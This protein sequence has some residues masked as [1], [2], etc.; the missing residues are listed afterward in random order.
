M[1][2]RILF[3]L[4]IS[5]VVGCDKVYTEEE[6]ADL[7]DEARIDARSET[8]S[9]CSV[10]Q[11]FRILEEIEG[12]SEE[13]IRALRLVDNDKPLGFASSAIL[14]QRLEEVQTLASDARG[15]IGYCR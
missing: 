6:V 1:P 7:L 9:S 10:D 3:L 15:K 8:K 13:A 11:V 12:T 2:R 4:A 14:R 5:I